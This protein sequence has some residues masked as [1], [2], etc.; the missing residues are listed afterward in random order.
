MFLSLTLKDQ[1]YLNMNHLK[2]WIYFNI[3]FCQEAQQLIIQ[4]ECVTEIV[5]SLVVVQACYC[6]SHCDTP[7]PPGAPTVC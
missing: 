7:Q 5:I 4:E 3:L 2:I 6:Y 1:T